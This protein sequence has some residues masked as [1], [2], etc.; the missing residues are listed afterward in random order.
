MEPGGNKIDG[1]RQWLE[2]AVCANAGQISRSNT[3]DLLLTQLI[4][5][6]MMKRLGPQPTRI[7]LALLGGI[8]NAPGQD[9][10]D[11]VFIALNIEPNP[12]GFERAPSIFKGK[13]K[14][15]KGAR[16]ERPVLRCPEVR[17][18]HCELPVT[19]CLAPRPNGNPVVHCA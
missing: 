1:G 11:Q 19:A 9:L 14:D 10:A 12:A 15:L 18:V 13:G 17:L 5:G 7:T 8:N 16:V 3:L 2:A 4:D 6:N